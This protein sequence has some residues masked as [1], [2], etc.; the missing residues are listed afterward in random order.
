MPTESTT[1]PFLHAP[2]LGVYAAIVAAQRR[3]RPSAVSDAFEL[4]PSGVCRSVGYRIFDYMDL[5]PTDPSAVCDVLGEL[6]AEAPSGTVMIHNVPES[7]PT[8]GVLASMKAEGTV[9]VLRQA[10]GVAPYSS[11]SE[12]GSWD[13]YISAR[14]KSKARKNLAWSHRKLD[15]LGFEVRHHTTPSSVSETLPSAFA[16]ATENPRGPRRRWSIS[17]PSGQRLFGQIALELASTGNVILSTVE[18]DTSV[19]AFSLSY[20][21]G[22]V[23][24]YHHA[25]AA[26]DLE[27]SR[28]SPGSVLLADLL[29]ACHGAGIERFD[30]MLGEEP[31]KES[32]ST[33]VQ[34]LTTVIV[35]SRR[36]RSRSEMARLGAL[37][38]GRDLARSALSRLLRR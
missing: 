34:T 7:S 10:T 31:Y 29:R 33:G 36:F 13:D 11:F 30:F 4:G 38:V 23:C 15:A 25:R 12:K 6:L 28:F 26:R 24:Y 3:S 14:R 1:T 9:R 5:G 35:S 19:L 16:V 37:Y 20:R 32:W 22:N 27:T 2:F 21:F 17:A 8:H 18:R